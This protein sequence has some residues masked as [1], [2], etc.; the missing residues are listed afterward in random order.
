MGNFRTPYKHRLHHKGFWSGFQGLTFKTLPLSFG[1]HLPQTLRRRIKTPSI[2]KR[3]QTSTPHFGKKETEAQSTSPRLP[4]ARQGQGRAE[5]Q[6]L[7]GCRPGSGR[8]HS[9][10]TRN[11]GRS[12]LPPPRS[13]A[14]GAVTPG[15]P[16]AAHAGPRSSPPLPPR[17]RP[18]GTNLVLC[19]P[20]TQSHTLTLTDTQSHTLPHRLTVSH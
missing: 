2:Q 18:V 5:V 7:P 4:T 3:Q 16:S 8:Q 13:G 12:S 11:G 6:F 9:F 19:P 17:G 15:A 20:H 10:P 14:K 1:C